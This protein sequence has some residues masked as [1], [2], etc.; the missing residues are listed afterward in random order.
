MLI[1]NKYIIHSSCKF[2]KG[3]SAY[4]I[5]D[6][7][8]IKGYYVS[9]RVGNYLTSDN[10]FK[11]SSN[12]IAEIRRLIK[13]EII[14]IRQREFVE[15]MLVKI[16]NY[17]SPDTISDLIIDFSKN[18]TIPENFQNIYSLI[19]NLRIKN[20]Q[21]NTSNYFHFN[22]LCDFIYKLNESFVNHIEI[23]I[24][25]I[26]V[27]QKQLLQLSLIERVQLIIIVKEQEHVIKKNGKILCINKDI[28]LKGMHPVKFSI[29]KRLF[30]ESKLHNNYYYKKMY[31]DTNGNLFNAP[32]YIKK[33]YNIFEEFN[34]EKIIKIISSKPF[35]KYW[36][37][38][39]DKCMICKDCEFRYMCV[40]N[41]L[42]YQRKDKY[43]GHKMD[44]NY[45]PYLNKWK[46]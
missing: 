14:F 27:N 33:F 39:K 5:Y 28:Y 35:K 18:Y 34:I 21:I 10:N 38:T 15:T 1:K 13:E 19:E 40:D 9:L 32:E 42:P 41:R 46:I 6:L 3:A 12:D 44:C 31:I 2:V 29:N 26:F 23:I 16:N 30:E 8:R 22:S 36:S 17:E 25:G 45:N 24:N 4:F 43:W 20:I 7:H 37:V 11:L